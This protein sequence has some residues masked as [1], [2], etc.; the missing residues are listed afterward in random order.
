MKQHQK[1]IRIAAALAV[2]T[3]LLTLAQQAQASIVSY[4]DRAA[5]TAASTSLTNIDFEG[6]APTGGYSDY[7][8]PSGLT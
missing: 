6:I 1:K 5:F 4:S 3:S 2:M 7:S 8:D